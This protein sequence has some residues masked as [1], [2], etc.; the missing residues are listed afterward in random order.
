MSVGELFLSNDD[1]MLYLTSFKMAA[2]LLHRSSHFTAS[3][4][5]DYLHKKGSVFSDI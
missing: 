1:Q 3:S 5:S 2:D 4:F